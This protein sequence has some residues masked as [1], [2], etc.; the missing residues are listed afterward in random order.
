M[1]IRHPIILFMCRFVVNR[2]RKHHPVWS[3]AD[4]ELF[5]D[6]AIAE[7]HQ[8]LPEYAPTPIKSLDKLALA[9]GLGRIIVKDEAQRFGLNA[10]KA[11]GASYA[12]YKWLAD[13]C[14][15]RGTP[16]PLPRRLF[17]GNAPETVGDVTF[18]T[19]TDGNHGRG[20]AWVARKLGRTA[21]IYM[22]IDTVP[23]RID[24]I[25]QLGADVIVVA[26]NYDD[27]VKEC[28]ENATSHG[29]QIVSD[30]SWPGYT[31][32]PRWIMA[33]YTTIF[34]EID[35]Q[36]NNTPLSVIIIQGGVGALAAAAAWYYNR[37]ELDFKPLLICVEPM[38]ADCLTQ[39]IETVDGKPITV[40][41]P[42][43]TIMAGL[44]CG[45]PSL[46]AWPFI[47]SGF[48]G[49]VVINDELCRDAMRK[50]YSPLPSDPQIVSGESGAASLA[51]LLAI[52]KLPSLDHARRSLS[53]T[54]QST[55]L[56]I[57]TE[58]DTDPV[59][60]RNIVSGK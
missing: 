36:S 23:A 57:N 37:S 2:F 8:S 44:N 56:L 41:T 16:V 55:V 10:F 58:G 53:L 18:C 4:N 13:R 3:R 30:T 29:W 45:T 25:K 33:A 12:V 28:T 20:V 46:V 50:Y 34:R 38:A 21:N 9:L 47:R 52:C 54:E 39:S 60:F 43:S 48:G 1:G 42:T 17:S 35:Q 51:A 15:Q 31:E 19:A 59:S 32:I 6:N 26:G 49:F 7:V 40:P 5:E 24:A 14:S 27:A 22:P 11:L